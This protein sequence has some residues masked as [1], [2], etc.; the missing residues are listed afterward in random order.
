MNAFALGRAGKGR[1]LALLAVCALLGGSTAVQA[2]PVALTPGTGV[3]TAGGNGQYSVPANATLIASYN[4]LGTTTITSNNGADVYTVTENVYKEAS[5]L[6]NG[7]PNPYAGDDEFVISVKVDKGALDAS[8]L[9][10]F[11]AGPLSV[12]YTTSN[13]ND[14]SAGSVRRAPA[15][16]LT[17]LVGS[18]LMEGATVTFGVQ[19]ANVQGLTTN[20]TLQTNDFS[21]GDSAKANGLFVPTPEPSSLVIGSLLGLCCIG[22][23]GWRRWMRKGSVAP[24]AV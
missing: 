17:Y 20:G 13:F 8:T 22:G 23:E 10:G 1:L 19:V 6:P 15:G 18:E 2:N 5:T 11:G 12:F 7:K 3:S 21:S 9:A 24:Q 16:N 4:P 14:G